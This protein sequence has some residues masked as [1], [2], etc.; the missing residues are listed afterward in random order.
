MLHDVF[1]Y[2]APKGAGFLIEVDTDEV[3]RLASHLKRFKLRAKIEVRV[4]ENGELHVWSIWGHH[5]SQSNPFKHTEIG[6]EDTRAPGMGWRAVLKGKDKPGDE[7]D[8]TSVGSYS[9]RRMLL[10][11]AEGQG[12]IARES[13]FPLE[14]NIDYMSGIDFRKGCYVGQELTIRTH[15]TGVVRKRILPVQIYPS[16]AGVVSL[17]TVTYDPDT[18]SK[19]I[20]LPPRGTNILGTLPKVRSV[21]KWLAGVGN[22]GLALCRLE[23]MTDIVLTGGG[24]SWNPNQKCMASWVANVGEDV[25]EVMVKAVVP[26][27]MRDKVL[28]GGTQRV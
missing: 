8:E 14:S 27:W 2:S 26:S 28:R 19:P 15:H 5:T 12:E 13:A 24:N 18:A 9:V 20:T 7:E 10:G 6:C 22:V 3:D 21:G 23:L 16:D 17:E 11:V 1:V 4:V 25:G